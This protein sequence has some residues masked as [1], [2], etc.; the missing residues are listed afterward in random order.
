MSNDRNRYDIV[1]AG[2][3]FAGSLTALI[4]RELGFKICLLEKSRHP[5]F[6]IGE[7]STPIADMILRD[8]SAKYHLP[9]LYPFSRYGSWQQSHPEIICGIKRGFSFFK[10]HPG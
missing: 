6:A 3:G 1:I 8:L 10:H 7:S 5:R 4:L 2:S 9:W